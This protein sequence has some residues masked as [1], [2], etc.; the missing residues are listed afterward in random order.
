[1]SVKVFQ[2][3]NPPVNALS[4]EVRR[5]LQAALSDADCE[6]I[7]L[8]GA[9][10]TFIGGADIREFDQAPL[11]PHLPDLLLAL[12]N[13]DKP[14]VAAINGAALGGGLEVALAAHYRIAAPTAT[15][16]CPEVKL[17]LIPG[18]GGTQRMPRLIGVAAASDLI[19]S[20]RT[21]GAA[22]ALELGLIDRIE[23]GDLR[24]AAIE[25]A[26]SLIGTKP[27][28]T[29]DKAVEPA[30]P[31]SIKARG[32]IAP[33]E[34][35]RLVSLA[36]ELP[37]A[38]GLAEERATFLRLRQSPQSAALR[39]VF[40]AE[41][42]SA[43]IDGLEDVKPRSLKTIGIVGTGLMGSG[44]AYAALK[45][46]YRVIAVDRT[47]QLAAQ[48][49]ERIE[50]LLKAPVHVSHSLDDLADA[51]LV[52]EAVFDIKT[53]LFRQLDAMV[54]PEAILATNTSYLDPDRIAAATKNPARVLGLHFFSPAHV[55][56][57]LEVVRCKATAP[58]VLAT[59]LAFGKKIGKLPVVCGVTEGF[60]GNRMFS[61]YRRETDLLLAEGALPAQ[62]DAAM[63]A[64]GFAMADSLCEAG[65]FGRKSGRGW[66]LYADGKRREDPEVTAMIE[67]A[68]TGARDIPAAEIVARLLAALRQEGQR[69]LAEGIAARPGDIDLVM[70]NGYGFPAHKGGPMFSAEQEA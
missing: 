50:T 69:L 30:P 16:A 36:A 68:R 24:S 19:A 25:R 28:R 57:L 63:E 59:G 47:E 64:Y 54:E 45:A 11:E 17:G 20:G 26:R 53:T 14:V 58:E 37:L 40:F 35:I 70:I 13:L 32:R 66:Y 43:K 22:E 15:F 23:I 33:V 10:K 31:I 27:V 39:H 60:I 42:A 52:I 67:A 61:A 9:G 8:I 7:V 65:R 55:M 3:D 2:I 4:V 56:R 29:G 62:I 1:M 48:G 12:E 5:G 34:A 18:A 21:V 44:I 38:D 51:D 41:R 46:G 49:K 6:A